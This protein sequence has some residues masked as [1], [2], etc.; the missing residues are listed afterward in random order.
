M[1]VITR[2][3]ASLLGGA[4]GLAWLVGLGACGSAKAFDGTTY[5]KGKL[6][7]R[8]GEIPSDW[9]PIAVHEATL[10][11]RDDAHGGSALL[12]ARCNIEDSDTPL[13]A[14]TAHLLTGTTERAFVNE[15][16]IPFDARE[17]RHTLVRAKLDGVLLTYDLYVLNKDGCTYDFA[18]IAPPE[19]FDAGAPAFE[20][21]V[22]GFQ[23]RVPRDR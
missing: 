2:F 22:R 7:F 6:A 5:E 8:V 13:A 11:F 9:H 12:N 15:E 14:L 20:R 17:A 4:V 3:L 19:T 16:T 1:L 21:F 10:A 18:Y 23:T